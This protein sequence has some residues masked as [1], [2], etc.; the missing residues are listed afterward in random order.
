MLT[1]NLRNITLK[2][3]FKTG[4]FSKAWNTWKPQ[5][6]NHLGNEKTSETILNL[7][8]EL[9]AIFK[10]TKSAKENKSKSEQQSEK[11]SAGHSFEALVCWYLNL[12]LKNSRAF[13]TKFH[14]DLVPKSIQD[15]LTITY[16]NFKNTFKKDTN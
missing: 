12:C 9:R 5:I 15:A 6:L 2:R 14:K 4:S 3:L 1:E 8:D 13:V 16:G 10:I 7:G 11:A